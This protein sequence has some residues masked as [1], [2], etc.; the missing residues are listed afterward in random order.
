MLHGVDVARY[1]PSQSA[2][3]D[4]HREFC[5]GYVGRLTTEKNVHALL[6]IERKLISTGAKNYRFLIVGEG[7]QEN[8]L[9]SHLQKAE[10]TGVLRGDALTAAYSRMDVLVF[11]S[12]TDTFGL[13]I[14]EAMGS[15]VPV[16]LSAETGKR[17]GVQDNVSGLL[18]NDFAASTL[19][20]MHDEALRK[21]MGEAAHAFACTQGWDVVFTRL[22]QT[23]EEG[24]RVEMEK[25]SPV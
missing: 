20:L 13:V 17:V 1:Q 5:I 8:W 16:I 2:S 14:L 11:P 10:F 22:Y 9:R 4:P 12:L 6:Q 21:A 3:P 7:G 19:Q 15:G 23:Y 24:L 25:G 18:S